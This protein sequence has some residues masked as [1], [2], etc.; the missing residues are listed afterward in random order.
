MIYA[1]L[2]EAVSKDLLK[3]GAEK[4]VVDVIGT[5]LGAAVNTNDNALGDDRFRKLLE[6]KFDVVLVSPFL[7]SEAGY[8]LAHRSDAALVMY[9]TGQVLNS[10]IFFK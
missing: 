4:T 7:C 6:K 2:T 10:T 8:H 1:A 9:F 5:L 3:E